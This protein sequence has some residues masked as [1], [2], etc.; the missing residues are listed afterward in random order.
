MQRFAHIMRPLSLGVSG[1]RMYANRRLIGVFGGRADR[2][3]PLFYWLGTRQHSSRA[4]RSSEGLIIIDTNFAGP[5][6]PE[7]IRDPV[8]PQ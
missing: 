6:E 2:H 8:E 7:I 5:T 3:H 4:L 1:M